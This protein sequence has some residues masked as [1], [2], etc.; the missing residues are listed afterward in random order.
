MSRVKPQSIPPDVSSDLFDAP[1]ELSSSEE[2]SSN[3][4]SDSSSDSSGESLGCG[5]ACGR[6]GRGQ[7]QCRCL[8]RRRRRS[9][10]GKGWCRHSAVPASSTLCPPHSTWGAMNRTKWVDFVGDGFGKKVGGLA[11]A[12]SASHEAPLASSRWCQGLFGDASVDC[13][14]T[15]TDSDYWRYTLRM[16]RAKTGPKTL[17]CVASEQCWWACAPRIPIRPCEL[18]AGWLPLW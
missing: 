12:V 7:P 4:A 1:T 18:L 2:S 9:S 3:S 17:H 15:L 14:Q 5:H 16:Q 11:E 6:R 8:S 10:L 13:Y